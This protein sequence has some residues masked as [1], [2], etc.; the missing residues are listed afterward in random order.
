MFAWLN[1]ELKV[2]A[3]GFSAAGAFLLDKG[4][5]IQYNIVEFVEWEAF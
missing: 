5:A 4:F 3:Y 1:D 2:P